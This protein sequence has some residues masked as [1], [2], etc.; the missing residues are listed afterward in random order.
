MN[1]EE[2]ETQE[3]V[4]VA[5]L[6]MERRLTEHDV[7]LARDRLDILGK[8]K[9]LAIGYTNERDWVDFHG[10]P[11]LTEEGC[12]KFA[13][14]YGVSFRDIQV[15]KEEYT[16]EEGSVICFY[17]SVIAI[18]QGREL[19]ADGAASTADKFFN[20]KGE[21]LRLCEIN[22]PNVRKKS[23]TSGK[24][25]ATKKILGLSFTWKEVNEGMK[26]TG[27]DM[28][29]T[30]S[31]TFD[32]G[33]QGGKSKAPDSKKI[34]D[35]RKLLG[36]LLLEMAKGDQEDAKNLLEKF[37]SFTGN[38]GSEVKGKRDLKDISERQLP[39]T[40]RKVQEAM[41]PSEDSEPKEEE[42]PF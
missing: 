11:Y 4:P 41:K 3:I 42:I 36:T 40:L 32:R 8:L 37:T 19:P 28:G 38:D 15:I 20:R 21:R 27:R 24:A 9:L 12:M 2:K 30:T 5:G 16:D 39:V 14:V 23:V 13:E 34:A 29:E 31:V 10:T 18:F 6:P 25:R 17:S 35:K 7:D 22:I 1:E 33:S 26:R